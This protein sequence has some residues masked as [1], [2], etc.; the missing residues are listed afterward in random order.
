MVISSGDSNLGPKAF[1]QL[2]FEIAPFT[3][4]P[5]RQVNNNHKNPG[6]F[7]A[8]MQPVLTVLFFL[9]GTLPGSAE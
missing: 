8:I 1:S 9:I 7:T 2:E 6:N 3:A 5:P 4:R